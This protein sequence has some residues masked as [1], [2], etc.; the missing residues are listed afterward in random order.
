MMAV[1]LVVQKMQQGGV[2][3]ICVAGQQDHALPD[4]AAR[5]GALLSRAGSGE[6]ETPSSL[7]L[8]VPGASATSSTQQANHLASHMMPYE[9][10]G[11][12]AS[13]YHSVRADEQGLST[14]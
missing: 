14:N 10:L 4:I 9:R 13:A 6:A 7:L 2:E 11:H 1:E 3:E 12:W 8:Y 5:Q